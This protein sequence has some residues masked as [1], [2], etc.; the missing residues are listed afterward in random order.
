MNI[1]IASFNLHRVRYDKFISSN[2]IAN[3]THLPSAAGFQSIIDVKEAADVLLGSL[4]HL[5]N[6]QKTTEKDERVRIVDALSRTLAAFPALPLG[7]NRR[8]NPELRKWLNDAPN[9]RKKNIIR[10]FGNGA[11]SSIHLNIKL[12]A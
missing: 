6:S 8:M 1:L 12:A 3:M 9:E 2:E 4:E 11:W 10:T 7:C 5:C